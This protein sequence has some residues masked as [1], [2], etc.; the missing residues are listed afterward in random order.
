MRRDE[1]LSDD[2]VTA[3]TQAQLATVVALAADAIIAVDGQH[4]IIFFNHGAERI[5][6]HAAAAMLASRWAPCFPSDCAAG[7]RDTF[8]ILRA[9]RSRRG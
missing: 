9:C 8:R 3:L 5:F 1:S 6:G 4:R 7:T 2:G